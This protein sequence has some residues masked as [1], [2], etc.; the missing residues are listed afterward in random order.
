METKFQDRL[1]ALRTERDLSQRALGAAIHTNHGTIYQLESGRSQPRG[2]TIVALARYFGVSADY[3]LG[4]SDHRLSA[5]ERL[6]DCME[7]AYAALYA[8]RE[9]ADNAAAA[10]REA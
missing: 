6:G 10:L 8:I 9:A 5:P 4:L 2:D 3:L 1:R 7:R